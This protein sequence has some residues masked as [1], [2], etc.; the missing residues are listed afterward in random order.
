[1]EPLPLQTPVKVLCCG[2]I[3]TALNQLLNDDNRALLKRMQGKVLQ[4]TLNELSL[5]LTFVF[6]QRIDVLGEYEGTPDC[7]LSL[8]LSVLPQLQQQSQITRLIKQDKLDVEGDLQL[9]QQFAELLKALKPDWEELL[10]KYT[11]DVVAHTIIS[12]GKHQLE[13][14][15]AWLKVREQDLAE[16]IT[17]EWK[18]A[19]GPLEVAHFCDQ[20]DDLRSAQAKL[21]ARIEQ[22]TDG[23]RGRS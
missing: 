6:S 4:V 16:V 3:E 13:Q 8:N 20:V 2:A 17:E 15:K 1:M 23:L 9:A 18:L 22:L 11:G 5:T 19:P 12:G 21:D 7:Q 10:S 14:F